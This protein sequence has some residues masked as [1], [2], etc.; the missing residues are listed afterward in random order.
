MRINVCLCSSSYAD[1]SYAYAMSVMCIVIR[2][3]AVF[4]SASRL[5]VHYL[6][7]LADLAKVFVR[8][9]DIV[10]VTADMAPLYCSLT[11]RHALRLH[12]TGRVV[13]RLA[14]AAP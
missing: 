12:T 5:H 13:D 14:T 4:H 9:G 2:V 3:V 11:Q 6:Y 10:Q 7:Q 8:L 1:Q